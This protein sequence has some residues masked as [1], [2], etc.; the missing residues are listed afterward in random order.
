MYFIVEGTVHM[1]SP[2]EKHVICVLEKGSYFGEFGVY[3]TTRRLSTFVS[4]TFS[5]IYILH[6]EKFQ[7]VLKNFPHVDFDFKIYGI[8]IQFSIHQIAT[9]RL[10]V[11]DSGSRKR[12]LKQAKMFL[13]S[14]TM[15]SIARQ[16]SFKDVP[17]LLKAAEMPL[18]LLRGKYPL[19]N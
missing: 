14:V 8:F 5:L 10:E 1:L 15:R 6:K 4:H 12:A 18:Y 16:K 2:N 13:K 9:K 3:T 19:A 11:Y 7:A 17:G